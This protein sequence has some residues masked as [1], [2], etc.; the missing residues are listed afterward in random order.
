MTP[1]PL[2]AIALDFGH[3]LIDERINILTTAQHQEA[4]LMPGVRDVLAALTLPVA[5]WANTRAANA[6]D[7]RRW[8]ERPGLA[9][10]V[11]WVVTS[12]D[13]RAGTQP[14]GRS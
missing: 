9:A 7:L 3:T 6:D 4:H 10:Q 1:H 13:A 11:T 12:V 14:A 5:I 8:L 2:K